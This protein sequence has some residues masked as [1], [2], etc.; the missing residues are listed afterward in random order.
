MTVYAP[1]RHP[2]AVRISSLAILPL[3]IVVALSLTIHIMA[4][5]PRIA[6]QATKPSARPAPSLMD[7]GWWASAQENIQ[8]SEYDV[9]WQSNIYLA[10]T[11]AYQAPNR[12]QN[13]RIYF[14]PS[15]GWSGRSSR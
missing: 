3:F 15:G 1:G 9:A 5:V 11:A 2:S 4:S 13:L 7:S 6:S 14:V 12:S 10:D 8:K